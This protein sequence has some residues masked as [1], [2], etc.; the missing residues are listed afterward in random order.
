MWLFA[1]SEY[2]KS[3]WWLT[4][5]TIEH[6]RASW[7]LNELGKVKRDFD[8]KFGK[9]YSERCCGNETGQ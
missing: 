8:G 6:F 9:D 1:E 3:Q 2:A 4:R 7:V 5:I